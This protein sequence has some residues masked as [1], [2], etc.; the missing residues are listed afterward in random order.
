MN[1]FMY[2]QAECEYLDS[3]R[4]Y[5]KEANLRPCGRENGCE[6]IC[7]FCSN[8]DCTEWECW[9]HDKYSSED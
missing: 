3:D 4:F 6:S 7:P 1:D 2:Y 9:E 8:Q 5:G